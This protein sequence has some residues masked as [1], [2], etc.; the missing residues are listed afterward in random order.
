MVTLVICVAVLAGSFLLTAWVLGLA[1][2]WVGSERGRFRTGLAAT[3]AVIGVGIV[4]SVGEAFFPGTMSSLGRAVVFLLLQF[5]AAFVVF[6]RVFRLSA[7]RAMAPL[8]ALVGLNV[9]QVVVL[10]FA[11]RPYVFESFVTPGR[12]MSPTIEPG[13]RFMTGKWRRPGRWD[14]VVYWGGDPEEPTKYVKRLIGLPGERL[15]FEGGSLYVNGHGA[16]APAVL[17][18]RMQAA[19]GPMRVMP[20]YREGEE[21]ALGA[22]EYFFIGD[23]VDLSADSRSRGPTDG[24]ALIGVVDFVYWPPGRVRLFR[25]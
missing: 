6:R 8:G 17:V 23:N 2:R 14:L 1:A 13:D 9:V 18:G 24:S 7:G 12:S 25:W 19:A 15:K 16:E 11:V 22:N 10:V 3:G 4:L 21:I 20:R 5:V